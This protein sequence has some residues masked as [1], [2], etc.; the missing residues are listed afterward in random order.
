MAYKIVEKMAI[1]D[2]MID[3]TGYVKKDDII[4]II[5]PVGHTMIRL[6]NKNPS[7]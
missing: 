2:K 3:L 6:D 7:S 4:N 5:A 1:D